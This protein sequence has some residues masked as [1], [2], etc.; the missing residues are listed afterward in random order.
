M[1]NYYKFQTRYGEM[2]IYFSEEALFALSLPGDDD[3]GHKYIH[4]YFDKIIQVNEDIFGYASE[5]LR[6]INGEIK[7]FSIPVKLFGTDFQN[8]V[9]KRLMDIPYGEIMTYKDMANSI[10]CPKGYRAV[11]NALNKNPIAIVVPCHR[12][13]GSNGKLVGFAGGISLKEKLLQLEKENKS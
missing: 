2:T 4:K 13:I 3:K 5:I 8:K 10:G 11:G 12:V 1:I 7:G 9:W 6:Y